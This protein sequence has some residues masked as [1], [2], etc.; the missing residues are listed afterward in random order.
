MTAAV[1][2]DQRLQRNLCLDVFLLLSLGDLLAEVVERGYVG[3]VVVLVVQFH[4]LAGDGGLE[5]AIVVCLVLVCD[6]CFSDDRTY[7]GDRA[8]WPC[9]EQTWCQRDQHGR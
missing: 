4:D 6:A 5:R 3:V 1:E 8:E 9:H 7:M 2:V